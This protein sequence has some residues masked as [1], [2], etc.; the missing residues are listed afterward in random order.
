MKRKVVLALAFLFTVG[1]ATAAKA[2][3]AFPLKVSA[4]SAGF[5]N[6]SRPIPQGMT[7]FW[8]VNPPD[9]EKIDQS[10]VQYLEITALTKR[11]RK[12]TSAF[13]RQYLGFS[14]GEKR[15]IYINAYL[16]ASG[17]TKSTYVKRCE[18][19]NQTWGIEY[20]MQ[21]KVFANFE[22]DTPPGDPLDGIKI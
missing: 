15:F 11:L 1:T 17:D 7:S 13:G 20:D 22:M 8:Q 21:Q 3:M 2:P 12:P 14:R 10:L 18:A 6:C 19:S 5:H 16:K 9:V 4:F